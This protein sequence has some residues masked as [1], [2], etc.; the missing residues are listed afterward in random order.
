[1]A[2]DPFSH[3]WVPQIEGSV[4]RIYCL[5]SKPNAEAPGPTEPT[6]FVFSY[7]SASFDITTTAVDN[8][9]FAD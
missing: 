7:Q 3:G 4:S 1:M 8:V 9:T 5:A 2:D 6:I